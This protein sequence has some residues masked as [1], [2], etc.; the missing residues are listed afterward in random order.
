MIKIFL[1]LMLSLSLWA[2]IGNVM[3]LKGSAEVNRV[4]ELSKLKAGM[5][6]LVGDEIIT[7]ARTRVQVMLKDDTI[8]T[9]GPKSNYKF[10]EFEFDGTQSSKVTMKAS[11]GF[12]R[13]ITGE[14][15]KVAP[16]RFKV[17]TASATIGIRGTDFTGSI[18][19]DLEIISCNKGEIF[20]E[21][22]NNSVNIAAG[23][24]V[25]LT[26]TKPLMIR[27]IEPVK[28]GQKKGQSGNSEFRKATTQ[29]SGGEVGGTQSNTI[30]VP[31]EVVGDSENFILVDSPK[32]EQIDTFGV[33]P[34][35][36]SRE[37]SF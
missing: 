35:A 29:S 21:Y 22:K 30:Y 14:I 9:I 23:M 31:T 19:K 10:E 25:E 37:S 5:E 4:S 32:V 13:T 3:A 24:L 11:R 6:L 8:I 26:R 15:G 20:V 34:G 27:K 17:K 2:S 36:E 28:K 12:F 7:Q 16:E 18:S 1:L 33:T